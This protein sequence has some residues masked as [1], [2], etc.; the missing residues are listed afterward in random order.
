MTSVEEVID[1]GDALTLPPPLQKHSL[2]QNIYYESIKIQK[3]NKGKNNCGH[4]P[5]TPHMVIISKRS[6]KKIPI[7][8][9]DT[10]PLSSSGQSKTQ[11]NPTNLSLKTK[12]FCVRSG[13]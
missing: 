11:K 1:R 7:R 4:S 6:H 12:E 5:I 2:T 9:Y 13:A 3:D 10:Q 8:A